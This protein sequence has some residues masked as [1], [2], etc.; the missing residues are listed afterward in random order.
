MFGQNRIKLL[1]PRSVRMMLDVALLPEVLTSLCLAQLIVD[2]VTAR[3]A[4]P[5]AIA[6]LLGALASAHFGALS[7]SGAVAATAHAAG[8]R[9]QGLRHGRRLA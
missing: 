7:S 9:G 5:R 4:K 6:W 1:F 2:C 3:R 8:A